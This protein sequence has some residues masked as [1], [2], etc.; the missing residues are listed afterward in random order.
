M[1]KVTIGNDV[2]EVEEGT[3]YEKIVEE[4]QEAYN[5]QIA[6]VCANGKIRELFKRVQ[7]DCV[8]TFVTLKDDVGHKSYVRSATMLLMKAH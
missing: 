6:L 5:N 1:V 8:L 4:Y 3:A 2:K 7:K